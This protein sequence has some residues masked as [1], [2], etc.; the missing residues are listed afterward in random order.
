MRYLKLFT[1]KPIV[2]VLALVLPITLSVYFFAVQYGNNY[3]AS[4]EVGYDQL[5]QNAL[6]RLLTGSQI[7]GY[8]NRA[9]DFILWGALAAVAL[10]VA[11]VVSAARTTMANHSA[12]ENFH[13][14]RVTKSSWHGHFVTE[15]TVKVLLAFLALYMVVLLLFK[16]IPDLSFAVGYLVDRVGVESSVRVAVQLAMIYVVQI[17]FVICV[18]AT[19]AVEID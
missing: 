16:L 7:T 14:F 8:F 19:R 4:N 17:V 15:L 6:T 12:V 10:L 3:I 2:W 5:Q 11:W 9:S 13:N 18:K 1:P